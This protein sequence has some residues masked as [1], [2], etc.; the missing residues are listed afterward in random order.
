MKFIKREDTDKIIKQQSKFAFICIQKSYEGCDSYTFKQNEILMDKTMYLA[1]TVKDMGELLKYETSYDKL[2]PCFGQENIHLQYLDT[3]SFVLIKNTKD[4]SKDLKKLE[5]IFDFSNLDKN[6]ELFSNK[7]KK[8]IGKFK[9]E[10]PKIFGLMSLFA[11]EVKCMGLNV[12][13]IVNIK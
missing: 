9:I 3:D 2:Q 5:D 6:H 11:Y 7:I 13:M 4:I 10:T 12:E 8:V 1:F